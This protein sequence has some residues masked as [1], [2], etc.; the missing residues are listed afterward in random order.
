MGT[1]VRRVHASPIGFDIR[2]FVV[3]VVS[4][5]RCHID[6]I[7]KDGINDLDLCFMPATAL[8]AAIRAK[9]VSAVEVVS[10]ILAQVEALEPMT[11]PR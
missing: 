9:T 2:T 1:R 5:Q 10:A 6:C 3:I 4:M 11:S 7:K 8:A